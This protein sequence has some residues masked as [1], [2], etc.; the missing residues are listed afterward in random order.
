MQNLITLQR[1]APPLKQSKIAHWGVTLN[2]ES[3]TKSEIVVHLANG[4]M[5]TYPPKIIFGDFN[6]SEQKDAILHYREIT[7]IGFYTGYKDDTVFYPLSD[8][9]SI[10]S[11]NK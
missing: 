11:N 10:I 1:L 3:D 8:I 5:R 7:S 2:Q 9:L 6:D 4:S